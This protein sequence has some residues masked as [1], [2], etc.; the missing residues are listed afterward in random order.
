MGVRVAPPRRGLAGALGVPGDKSIAHRALLLGALAEGTT[1]VTGFPGGADVLSTLGAVRALGVR[2]ERTGDTVRVEGAGP[3]LGAP[4]AI[5]IDCGNSGTTL[6]LVAGLVAARPG[7]VL[8][9]G[10]ASLRRRPMERIAEPL[11]AMGARV[12][13]LAG[14][15]PVTVRGARLTGI[16]WTLP[17]ASAQVKS[18]VLLA[19]LRAS[20]TTRV[21]EPLPS[22]DHTE[23]LLAH[24]GVP[25]GRQGNVIAVEGGRRLAAAP[26]ALPGDVSSAAFLVVAALLVPGSDLLLRDVGVNPTRTGFLAILRRMGA[27]IEVS[28]VEEVAGEPRATLRVRAGRL[29]GTRIGPAEVPASIDEL[30]ALCVAAALAEGETS[31]AGAGE[32]RVKESD[33]LAALEQLRLLGAD[34]RPAADGLAIRGTA[35]RP[36]AAGRV[37][38]GGD[39]RIAMAFAVAGLAS[40]GGVEVADP[41]CVEVSFPGFFDRLVEIGA[42][43]GA[44]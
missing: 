17:V 3:D 21:R 5:G 18:A 36:L 6:R 7:A 24:L 20:G 4:D 29:R 25:V 23:R 13:T 41:D 39:H 30:P 15:P 44:A 1:V 27:T 32:L 11:R 2:A 34:V 14:R 38:A 42:V 35:G 8:L 22:R 31:L 9:D 26:L 19:G 16:D 33:R 37:D 12:E 40:D 10:D 28:G 43:V